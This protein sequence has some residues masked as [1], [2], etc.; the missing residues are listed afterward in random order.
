PAEL[1]LPEHLAQLRA[2]RR[3]EHELRG[4]AFELQVAAHGCELLRA[5]RLVRVLDQI[6]TPRGWLL[7]GMVEH[8]LQRAVL[9]DQLPGGLVADS[10]NA[11]DVVGR[12][13]LEADEVRHLLGTDAVPRLDPLRRI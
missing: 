8:L 2:V 5:S 7:V 11:G 4:I 3:L 1:E 12:V 9:S 13:P 10:G 6:S